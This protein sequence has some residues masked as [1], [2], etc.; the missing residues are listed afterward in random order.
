MG[1]KSA[2]IESTYVENSLS[3][4]ADNTHI[5]SGDSSDEDGTIK[6]VR[7]KAMSLDLEQVVI[8]VQLLAIKKRNE[9]PTTMDKT[10]KKAAVIVDINA[11][12]LSQI[13][14]NDRQYMEFAK[15]VMTAALAMP[16]QTNGTSTYKSCD[17][18]L[19]AMFGLS[20]AKLQ[21]VDRGTLDVAKSTI[22]ADLFRLGSEA[23][24][25]N[26]E[27]KAGMTQL[28]LMETKTR[29]ALEKAEEKKRT[30]NDALIAS[31]NGNGGKKR[32]KVIRGGSNATEVQRS[33][34]PFS[35]AGENSVPRNGTPSSSNSV[36]SL[37]EKANEIFEALKESLKQQGGSGEDFSP[38]A[39]MPLLAVAVPN[40]VMICNNCESKNGSTRTNCWKCE[41]PL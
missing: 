14:L 12:R 22:A 27:G 31:T 20:L 29:E 41:V 4:A 39:R 10:K 40:A 28:E 37:N 32:A 5:D 18:D 17:M 11:L 16:S 19:K 26:T 9:Y 6:V 8:I 24:R 23:V 35:S 38:V 33:S 2:D 15:K 13:I 34:V 1:D 3:F 36:S 25:P 7:A 30:G 21:N